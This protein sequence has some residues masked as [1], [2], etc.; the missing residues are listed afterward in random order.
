MNRKYLENFISFLMATIM[1][2]LAWQSTKWTNNI[3]TLSISVAQLNTK[4]EVVVNEISHTS[5]VFAEI[6]AKDEEQDKQ[7]ADHEARLRVQETRHGH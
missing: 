2:F 1:A 3:E 6:K 4:M 5:Q 7:L